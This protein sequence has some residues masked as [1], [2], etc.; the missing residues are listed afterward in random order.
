MRIF[1]SMR[2]KERDSTG[3]PFAPGPSNRLKNQSMVETMY[4][5][6]L[7]EYCTLLRFYTALRHKMS[8]FYWKVEKSS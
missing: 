1:V 5:T 7:T 6:F 2:F 4:I 8:I 3:G